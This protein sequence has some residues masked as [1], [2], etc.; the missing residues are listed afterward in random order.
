M[1]TAASQQ[2]RWLPA[3]RPGYAPVDDRSLAELLDFAARFAGLITYYGV[4]D[5]PRGDWSEFFSRDPILVLA[6]IATADVSAMERGLAALA[7]RIRGERR[8]PRQRELLDELFQ[9]AL[10]LPSQIDRWLRALD[11]TPH[12]RTAHLVR[13]W[14]AAEMRDQLAEQLRLLRGF[15]TRAPQVLAR[16]Y[17]RF[18]V[19]WSLHAAP[20][21]SRRTVTEDTAERVVSQV[22]GAWRPIADAVARWAGAAPSRIAVALDEADGDHPPHVALFVAFVHLLRETQD[23]INDFAARR[24]DFYVRRILRESNRAEVPDAVYVAFDAAS[25]A[26]PAAVTLPAGTRL[27]GG[28]DSEGRDRIFV[29]RDDLTV[30]DATLIALRTVRTVFGKAL[31]GGTHYA[32]ERIVG[33]ELT[34]EQASAGGFAAFGALDDAPAA[35]G[36]AVGAPALWL[37]AGS[38]TI[39]IEVRCAPWPAPMLEVLNRLAAASGFDSDRVLEQLLRGAFAVTVSTDAGWW[40]VDGYALEL[41]PAADGAGFRLWFT[42]PPQAPPIAAMPGSPLAAECPAVRVLLRQQRITLDE[43]AK[44]SAYP[45]SVLA[46]LTVSNVAVQVKVERLAPAAVETPAGVVDPTRPFPAFGAM[47]AVGSYLKLREPELLTK[48]VADLTIRVKWFALPPDETGFQAY[49][50]GYVIGANG[51]LQEGLFDNQVFRVKI[52]DSE[53]CLFRTVNQAGEAPEPDGRLSKQTAF[54]AVAVASAKRAGDQE[55]GVLRIELTAPPYAFGNGIYA[56][57]VVHAATAAPTESACEASCQAEYAFLLHAARNVES[58]LPPLTQTGLRGRLVETARVF[59]G[60]RTRA[61]AVGSN[62][63]TILAS[64]ADAAAESLT[65]CLAEWKGLFDDARLAEWQAQAAACRRGRVLERLAGCESLLSTLRDR[66][67]SK[68]GT[69]SSHLERCELILS[70]AS[71]V[72]DSDDG[73]TDRSEWQYRRTTRA[74]LMKCISE[75]R[76]R[77][78]AAVKAC[79][80]NCLH[81]KLQVRPNAPF[82]PQVESLWL[83]YSCATPATL[84]AHLLP[85]DGF[86]RIGDGRDAGLPFLLP[87][88][89][90]DGNLYLGFARLSGPR[91]LPLYVQIGEGGAVPPRV[92][93]SYLERDQ[94][95]TLPS[96]APEAN[97]AAHL[98]TSGIFEL[99][100]PAIGDGAASSVLPGP[101]RWIRAGALDHAGEASRVVGIHPHAVS[102]VRLTDTGVPFDQALPAGSIVALERP[103]KDIALVR[104]PAPS[105]GGR[106]A[107]SD[108]D[109][110]V[111][112]SERLRHKDRAVLGWDY[113]HLVLEHFPAIWKVRVLPAH[114]D[115]ASAR[116]RRAGEVRVIVVPGPDSPDVADPTAPTASAETLASIERVLEQA[117]GPFVRV[118]VRNAT[119]VRMK[120]RANVRWRPGED[121][122]NAEER[123]I[124]ELKAYLAP[125]DGGLGGDGGISEAVA[126]FVQSRPYVEAATSL[127][128]EYDPPEALA[129][130]PECCYVTTAATHAISAEVAV[131]AVQEGY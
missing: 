67:A 23:S 126:E 28:R 88:F 2:D 98:R 15:D 55:H 40:S 104:Q 76:A 53:R 64:L 38:R 48:D 69:A 68:P 90:Y 56:Q 116:N 22:L 35:I 60:L 3:L 78:A 41:L 29:S 83:E 79:T 16:E 85:F 12:S 59:R 50:R 11:S 61:Q 24:A 30:T 13:S 47:P 121:G 96:P 99:M 109:L 122:R 127:A 7:R 63:A 45:L 97:A 117:A 27:L 129:S 20:L 119:F 17:S 54:E 21:E 81:R 120:V 82:V 8:S 6:S 131:P 124:A 125:W 112:T 18:T 110:H 118:Q 105:F 65:A 57:N 91:T 123:L 74:N 115:R 26:T 101:L 34:P 89:A 33:R 1:N 58:V 86:R 75:L 87:R 31:P 108:R 44:V 77:Y 73:Y 14:I 39:T 25:A 128:I 111:R 49:Y 19:D 70:A 37:R 114:A 46:E 62:T 107:E 130:E 102:A 113:E 32:V 94:W 80:A 92:S 43:H 10:E 84:L 52:G 42:V 51:L 36:F 103:V 66:A 5:R 9:A 100:L 95:I 71:W 72:Q 93:W 106:V 4:D